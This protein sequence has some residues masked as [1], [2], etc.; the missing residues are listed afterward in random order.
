VTQSKTIKRSQF[1]S[2]A[3]VCTV[4]PYQTTTNPP[5]G[6]AEAC[7]PPYAIGDTRNVRISGS[8]N[9]TASTPATHRE[10]VTAAATFNGQ[11]GFV[12]E[13][14]QSSANGN[15]VY[16]KNYVG[17]GNGTLVSFGAEAY[18]PNGGALLSTSVNDPA[19]IEMPRSFNVGET[20]SLAWVVRA[21]ASGFATNID[22]Y[23]TWKLVGRESV[24]VPAGTF[25]ACKFEITAG[26]NSNTAGVTT[27]TDLTGTAWTSASFGLVK[28]VTSGTSRVTGFG[29]NIST[30]LTGTTELLSATV[31]GQSTP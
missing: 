9:G 14:D 18:A 1:G 5:V 10:R 7:N 31:G 3:S 19:R 11:S 15:G 17:N 12:Q 16:A 25:N 2:T 30:N 20:K 28:Q 27:D 23:S 26:E 22:V 4:E 21:T 29:Q 13:F 6:G 8:S 24:T